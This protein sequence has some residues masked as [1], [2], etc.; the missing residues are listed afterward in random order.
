M[1]NIT[2]RKAKCTDIPSIIQI[3]KSSL[4]VVYNKEEWIQLI[5]YH[6]TFI[7]IKNSEPISYITTWEE[8]DLKL[9]PYKKGHIVT[10][11]TL[12]EYRSQGVGSKLLKYTIDYWSP[13]P[14]T[15]N[16]MCSN[17]RAIKFYKKNGF[18]K[19]RK[20][21]NY[22]GDNSDGIQFIIKERLIQENLL[23]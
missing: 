17:K 4:P 21:K 7:A 12:P 22:Y 19:Y 10:F 8:P 13:L 18:T 3:N 2:I 23:P 16:V 11:A 6:T 1:E 5:I 20:L 15:L 9:K 14:I